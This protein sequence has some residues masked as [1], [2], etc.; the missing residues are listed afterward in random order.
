MISIE[1]PICQR[2]D[3]QAWGKRNGYELYQCV[4]C[5]HKFA[6]LR[7]QEMPQNDTERFR[8]EFTH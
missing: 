1:C 4:S 2:T 5:T 3:H 8:E 7:N 6:D